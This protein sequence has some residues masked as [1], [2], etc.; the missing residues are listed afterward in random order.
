MPPPVGLVQTAPSPPPRLVFDNSKTVSWG[1]YNLA[2]PPA[3]YVLSGS[4]IKVEVATHQA[5]ADY[6]KF[7]K[8]TEHCPWCNQSLHP[9]M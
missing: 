8:V 1:Y 6:T 5:G 2:A 7:I 4:T 3:A 9:V